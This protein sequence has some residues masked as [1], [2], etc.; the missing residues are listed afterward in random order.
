M[1]DEMMTCPRCDGHGLIWCP[2]CEGKGVQYIYERPEGREIPHVCSACR[3]ER[4]YVC[5]RCDGKGEIRNPY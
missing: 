5:P 2:S 1:S 4:S 3:G